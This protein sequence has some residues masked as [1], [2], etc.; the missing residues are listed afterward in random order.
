M[1]FIIVLLSILTGFMIS[2]TQKETTSATVSTA[3]Y[4]NYKDSVEAGGVKMIPIT[5][6]V[7]NFKVWTKR[8]G[9]NPKI[10]VLLL[11]GGPAM[12]HEYMECFE[13]FFQREGFEFYEYDQLGSYYSDQPTDEKLWNIDRFV[14]EV[15]QVR[16]AIHADKENFYVLGNSWGG[17]LAMEY[18][19][20]Y[21]QNLKGLI[22]ANM[23]ASAPEYV[24]YAEVLSKQMKPEV[25][26][27]VRAIEAKKDYAN[28][29]Y[30][31][32]LFPNYYAQHI[33]RLKEWPDALNRSLKHVNSTVYTLMQGPSELGMSS[34]A[35][36]AK[37]DIKNRLNE[38]ATPTLMIGARYDTMDPKAMEEQ[39]KL[40]Q[41]GR[42]LYCPNGSHLAMWDDQ[43]VFMDGV[44]K[45]IKD[46]DTKSFN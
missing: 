18:A 11:H 35:R 38:I 25:L 44:I 23:M 10:K 7:G 1:R 28:P 20:K 17:I 5:T 26:A 13:T 15:E 16:K 37:W 2:C 32:L 22:V 46:V 43:K 34:D 9:T 40:V 36:L 42:Y 12:T 27:E 3:D 30:T 6:P 45:F 19:L 21:Q 14:D 24:K 33:C 29:R 8:F 4:F 39:S 31:E 41:K